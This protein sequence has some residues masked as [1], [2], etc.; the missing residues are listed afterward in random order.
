MEPKEI[1]KRKSPEAKIQEDVSNYLK[2]RN[3]IVRPVHASMI[4]FGWPDLYATHPSWGNRWIEIKLPDMR[5]SSFT[6][7]QMK[8][9]PEFHYN[10]SPIWIM[11]AATKTEYNK[12]WQPANFPYYWNLWLL[13]KKYV[14]TK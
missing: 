12:L 11:T 14:N 9:F 7:A 3:W 5:G 13:R 1:E 2:Y 10:G 6:N 4:S 8:F